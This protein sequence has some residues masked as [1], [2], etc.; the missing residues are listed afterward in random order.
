MSFSLDDASLMPAVPFA[1]GTALHQRTTP[2]PDASVYPSHLAHERCEWSE[3]GEVRSAEDENGMRLLF[4]PLPQA[5]PQARH[6]VQ[7]AVTRRGWD[8]LIEPV[9]LLFTELAANAIQHSTPAD[10][11]PPMP[12]IVTVRF[13]HRSIT[14]EVH[15]AGPAAEPITAPAQPP[16]PDA[17]SGRGLFLVEA[18]A[19]DWGSRS[20]PD[21]TVIWFTL[22]RPCQ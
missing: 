4:P 11:E 15:N 9:A 5:I 8:E 12:V 10:G 13:D 2:V 1:A 17:E 7:H 18:L 19:A 20:H 16:A 6:L 22:D 21:G 14:V 3:A